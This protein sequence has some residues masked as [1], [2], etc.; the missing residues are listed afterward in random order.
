MSHYTRK[1]L[2]CRAWWSHLARQFPGSTAPDRTTASGPVLSCSVPSPWR[3]PRRPC[4]APGLFGTLTRILIIYIKSE[5]TTL[6]SICT[7]SKREML[8]INRR[9]WNRDSRILDQTS[10]LGSG[11]DRVS[12]RPGLNLRSLDRPGTPRWQTRVS[13]KSPNQGH[14]YPLIHFRASEIP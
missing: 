7:T 6:S 14:L 2:A 1:G 11:L 4:G 12:G 3:H 13:R 10:Q 8:F 9:F 5:L